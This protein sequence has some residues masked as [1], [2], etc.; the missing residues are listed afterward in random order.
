MPK[1]KARKSN[2]PCVLTSAEAIA[3][4]GETEKEEQAARLA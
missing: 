4:L 2:G 3:M 1:P